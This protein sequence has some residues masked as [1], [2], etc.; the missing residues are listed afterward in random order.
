MTSLRAQPHDVIRLLHQ[1]LLACPF[2]QDES[3]DALEKLLAH[4]VFEWFFAGEQKGVKYPTAFDEFL[5]KSWQAGNAASS[6]A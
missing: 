5:D 1:A 4:V 2:A 3:L 6:S